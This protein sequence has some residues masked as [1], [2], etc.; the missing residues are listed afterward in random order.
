M[1]HAFSWEKVRKLA[2]RSGRLGILRGIR[3]D[4]IGMFTATVH[5]PL[6]GQRVKQAGAEWAGRQAGGREGVVSSFELGGG[7]CILG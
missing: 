1:R 3:L 4:S 7:D 5:V 2:S 6:R